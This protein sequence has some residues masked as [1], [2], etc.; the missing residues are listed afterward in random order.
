MRLIAKLSIYLQV[1]Y[2]NENSLLKNIQPDKP[3][4]KMFA[5]MLKS[6]FL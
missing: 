6:K 2:E 5:E 3:I 4:E 1:N